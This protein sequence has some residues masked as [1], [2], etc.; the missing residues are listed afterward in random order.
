M[1]SACKCRLET[2]QRGFICGRSS[3]E[4]VDRQCRPNRWR[5]ARSTARRDPDS[6]GLGNSKP[7]NNRQ[8]PTNRHK[9]FQKGNHE[10]WCPERLHQPRVRLVSAV[11]LRERTHD[12]YTA[13]STTPSPPAEAMHAPLRIREVRRWHGAVAI[14]LITVAMI[15]LVKFAMTPEGCSPRTKRCPVTRKPVKCAF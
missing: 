9:V 4:L 2:K 11:P 14:L 7:R 6:S 5:T 1:V 3:K 8:R 10:V 15:V 12:P 13:P